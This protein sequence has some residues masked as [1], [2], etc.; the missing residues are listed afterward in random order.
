[1]SKLRTRCKQLSL[2]KKVCVV[3]PLL[4]LLTFVGW[5]QW[6][7]WSIPDIGEP[8]DVEAYLEPYLDENLENAFDVYNDAFSQKVIIQ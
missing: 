7:I 6:R 5:R 2:A 8:F 1:M 3:T 4:F